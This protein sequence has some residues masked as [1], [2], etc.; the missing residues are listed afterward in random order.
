[1]GVAGL[2]LALRN[3]RTANGRELFESRYFT[4]LQLHRD[5][6]REIELPG[7]NSR[8]FFV[9]ALRELR[10]IYPIARDAAGHCGQELS[11]SELLH[12]SYYCLFYGAGPHSSRQLKRSLSSFD[13]QLVERLNATL[14]SDDTKGSVKAEREFQY[15][16]FEG[17]QSRL[18]HYYRHLYQTISYIDQQSSSIDRYGYVK[19]VRAQLSTHEQA[20]LLINSLTPLGHI[21][22]EKGFMI[23][24]R[25]VQNIPRDFFEPHELDVSK[26][27]PQ[28]YFEWEELKA[29]AE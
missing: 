16:P 11:A 28:N 22:W 13:S 26:L 7:A 6:V 9:E 15:T 10:S 5:N 29:Q 2:I 1:M 4:L 3:H 23:K 24:Y 12:V 14:D 20:L 27:F 17:H 19:T 18:G 25:L 21:W 8:K